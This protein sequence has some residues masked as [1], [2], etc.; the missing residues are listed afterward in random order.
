MTAAYVL[1]GELAKTSGRHEEAFR[2]YERALRDY[3]AVKQRGAERFASAFAPKTQWG[4]FFRNQVL[5]AFAIPGLAK[6]AFGRDLINRL[7][8]PDYPW[9]KSCGKDRPNRLR[10]SSAFMRA[11]HLLDDGLDAPPL[12][13]LV[14]IAIAIALNRPLRSFQLGLFAVR[15]Q[16]AAG[17]NMDFFHLH[18]RSSC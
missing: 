14:L 2:G 13:G 1:A 12:L 17:K 18:G 11:A 5:K 15:A 3:I 10:D 9:Q 6:L 16:Q 8:L 7:K 4:L